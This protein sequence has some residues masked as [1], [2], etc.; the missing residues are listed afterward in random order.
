MYTMNRRVTYSQV[1]RN[2]KTDMAMVAHFF[3]DCTIFHSESIGKGV[4]A[5]TSTDTAWFLSSWQIEVER[6][7]AFGEEITVRTWPHD[8]KGIYG[9]RNFDILDKEGKRMA[10][11]NSIWL[12]MDLANGRPA[13]PTEEDL[14][15]YD[16]EPSHD[17]AYLP[18]KIKVLGEENLLVDGS[19]IEPI[20]VKPSFLDSNEHVNNGRYLSEAMD[21]INLDKE[22]HH[23]RVDYRKAA[24]LGDEMYPAVFKNDEVYQVVFSDNEGNP[25]VIV[26]VV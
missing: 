19:E 22:I 12:F 8:F 6:Y 15:G 10:R 14:V 3:Q 18:R 17:L 11:A 26:E 16:L 4:T 13:K 23:M 5:A 20:K 9:Y 25:F 24:A 1:T 21:Y 7:P 2:L